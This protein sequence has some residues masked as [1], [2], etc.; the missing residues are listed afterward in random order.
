MC[1]FIIHAKDVQ[2]DRNCVYRAITNMLSSGDNEW[3]QVRPDMLT[4]LNVFPHLY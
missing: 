2:S 3:A 4:E 1:L